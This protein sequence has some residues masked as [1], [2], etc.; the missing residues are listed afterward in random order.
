VYYNYT[1]DLEC[2]R[3]QAP[4]NNES[5][6]VNALWNYQ[7]C[8]EI[9]QAFGQ[10][11]NDMDMYWDAPWDG[12]AV[13]KS[14]LDQYGFYPDRLHFALSFGDR[15]DWARSASNIVWSQGEYDP[16]KGGGVTTN[17]SDSLTGFVISEAAHHL[18]LFFSN[19]DDPPSVVAARKLEMAHVRQWIEEKKEK[20][21]GESLKN[22][23]ESVARQ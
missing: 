6:V 3:F 21:K 4:V 16:W 23:G 12:D 18:D 1:F 8:S 7:Y 9:F 10:S 15:S 2:N 20:L 5:Q 19:E 11:A 17:L 13:A 14:C 22:L